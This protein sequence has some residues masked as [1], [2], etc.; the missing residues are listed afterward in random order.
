MKGV[1]Y[2]VLHCY[3]LN[4][5]YE[6]RLGILGVFTLV[7]LEPDKYHLIKQLM[8]DTIQDSLT[9]LTSDASFTW[10][11]LNGLGAFILL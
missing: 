1:N 3:N 4:I 7:F 5:C 10:T 6:K 9:H 11:V 2:C 8:E